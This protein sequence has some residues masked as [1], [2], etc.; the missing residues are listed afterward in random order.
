MV[1]YK[2][3]CL[4]MNWGTGV[5]VWKWRSTCIS[6]P[7]DGVL[8]SHLSFQGLKYWGQIQ[9]LVTTRRLIT[10]NNWPL[11]RS[12]LG[13][14]SRCW[15]RRDHPMLMSAPGSYYSPLPTRAYLQ[16][17]FK[18][19]PSWYYPEVKRFAEYAFQAKKDSEGNCKN[20]DNQIQRQ[21]SVNHKKKLI[22]CNV[23]C[24]DQIFT[25]TRLFG[26]LD[27]SA[28]GVQINQKL[29]TYGQTARSF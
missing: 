13:V 28:C 6:Q 25:A 24:L 5:V 27:P 10:L 2:W 29:P 19:I 15:P 17:N 23:M 16:Y 4:L 12:M 20:L 8:S 9:V 18:A 7:S 3:D 21:R 1:K 26:P 14:S 22:M 11:R